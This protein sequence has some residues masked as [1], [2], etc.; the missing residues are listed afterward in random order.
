MKL[1]GTLLLPQALVSVNLMIFPDEHKVSRTTNLRVLRS[2]L[3]EEHL[4]ILFSVHDRVLPLSWE[5]LSRGEYLPPSVGSCNGSGCRASLSR[6]GI[7][8]I[9]PAHATAAAA[10][11]SLSRGGICLIPSTSPISLSHSQQWLRSSIAILPPPPAAPKLFVPN[12]DI[13]IST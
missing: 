7:C 4:G 11:A 9:P 8:F 12:V 3:L 2:L 13:Y 5:S 10:G 1:A 6:G